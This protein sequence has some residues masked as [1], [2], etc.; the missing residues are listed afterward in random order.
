M[1]SRSPGRTPLALR[2]LLYFAFVYLVLIAAMG[3]FLF[4]S[5]ESAVTESLLDHL[6]S[7]ARISEL[8]MPADPAEL[9]AWAASMGEAGGYRYTVI[10]Q[11]GLVLADSRS[12][13]ETMENHGARPEVVAA[14]DGEPG[15]ARRES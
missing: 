15:R 13:P 12:D 6:E 1:S 14:R 8:G 9:E 2:F 10:H 3:W 11:D 7:A 5:V 4:R